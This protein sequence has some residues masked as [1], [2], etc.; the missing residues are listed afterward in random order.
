M[1]R[2]VCTCSKCAKGKYQPKRGQATCIKCDIVANRCELSHP[3]RSHNLYML[4]RPVFWPGTTSTGL[5]YASSMTSAATPRDAN[6]STSNIRRLHLHSNH[7]FATHA[8]R[9]RSVKSASTQSGWH[10]DF[11]TDALAAAQAAD[12]R[13]YGNDK[14]LGRPT[15]SNGLARPA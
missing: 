4:T 10:C 5:I 11:I 7:M 2:R 15:P 3:P 1:T 6:V 13:H 12:Q 8:N 14:G 9:S